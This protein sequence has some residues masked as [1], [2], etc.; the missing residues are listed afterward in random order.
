MTLREV[1]TVSAQL[2]LRHFRAAYRAATNANVS[3]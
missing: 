1:E 3:R 2:T